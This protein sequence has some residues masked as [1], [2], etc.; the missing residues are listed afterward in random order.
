MSTQFL[1]NQDSDD[2]C[3]ALYQVRIQRMITSTISINANL[4]I[5]LQLNRMSS[6]SEKVFII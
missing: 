5:K 1:R 3:Y 4:L 2:S 6:I